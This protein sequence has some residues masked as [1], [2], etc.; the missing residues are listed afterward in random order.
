MRL[1]SRILALITILSANGRVDAQSA[2]ETA[3]A[4]YPQ[5]AVGLRQYTFSGGKHSLIM[6]LRYSYFAC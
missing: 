1:L 6:I 5:C 2:M 3:E 4:E